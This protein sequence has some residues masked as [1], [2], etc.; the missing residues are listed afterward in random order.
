MPGAGETFETLRQIE[1]LELKKKIAVHAEDY[2]LAKQFKGQIA[3]LQ[4]SLEPKEPPPPPMFSKE[5]LKKK[6]LPPTADLTDE[7]KHVNRVEAVK[8]GIINSRDKDHD[9]STEKLFA[10]I[11][12]DESGH[13]THDVSTVPPRAAP[14]VIFWFDRLRVI[15]GAVPLVGGPQGRASAGAARRGSERRK[16]TNGI[17]IE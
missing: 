10:H 17:I 14:L 3:Q 9:G 15:P 4:K 1:D 13:L 6:N 2:D 8:Q 16:N 5:N 12:A 7:E 11:D